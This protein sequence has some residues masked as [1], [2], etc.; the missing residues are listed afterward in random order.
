MQNVR[1]RA[2]L[3]T[4][5][6]PAGGV[7]KDYIH[8]ILHMVEYELIKTLQWTVRHCTYSLCS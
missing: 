2:G 4:S 5:F 1:G 6:L 8:I 7:Q 3:G